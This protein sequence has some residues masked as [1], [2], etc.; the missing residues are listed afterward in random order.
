M[1]ESLHYFA[2]RAVSMIFT[3]AFHNT[4]YGRPIII[5][6]TP[7]CPAPPIIPYNFS[8]QFFNTIRYLTRCDP[9]YPRETSR[10]IEICPSVDRACAHVYASR[11]AQRINDNPV[12]RCRLLAPTDALILRYNKF[13]SET[14][15]SIILLDIKS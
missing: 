9:P 6:G 8:C 3:K 5:G 7:R 15:H 14:S 4:L 1:Q 2:N 10:S 13:D 11:Y 12:S